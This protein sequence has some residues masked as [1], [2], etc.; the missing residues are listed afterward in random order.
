MDISRFTKSALLKNLS[1]KTA[2]LTFLKQDSPVP[3]MVTEKLVRLEQTF[4]LKM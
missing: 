4:N 1:P 3:F 2:D